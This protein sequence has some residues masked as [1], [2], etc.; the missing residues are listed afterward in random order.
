LLR[1]DVVQ[2]SV[3]ELCHGREQRAGQRF[4]RG[5]FSHSDHCYWHLL[6]DGKIGLTGEVCLEQANSPTPPSSNEGFGRRY[7][8]AIL[9]IHHPAGLAVDRSK[10]C[11]ICCQSGFRR[12]GSR[13]HN[14]RNL[15]AP[16]FLIST[17]CTTTGVQL[18]N[19]KGERQAAI[20]PLHPVISVIPVLRKAVCENLVSLLGSPSTHQDAT[21]IKIPRFCKLFAT[22]MMGQM[23]E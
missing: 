19:V 5:P 20:H 2:Y 9:H 10:D 22:R 12:R 21:Q 16:D 17:Y 23:A 18:R 13:R 14:T 6:H 7:G 4:S 8:T 15:P 3:H 11:P 1:T